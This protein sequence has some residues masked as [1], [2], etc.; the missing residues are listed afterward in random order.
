MG[1][2]NK[3]IL[4]EEFTVAYNNGVRESFR[5]NVLDNNWHGA[6]GSRINSHILDE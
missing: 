1:T 3:N 6:K 4:D 2:I 5:K